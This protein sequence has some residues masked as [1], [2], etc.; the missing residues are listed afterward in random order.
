MCIRGDACPYAH[1][2]FESWL[3]PTRY[4]TQLCTDGAACRRR[5]CFFAHHESEIRAPLPNPPLPSTERLQL[6]LSA[7]PLAPRRR[8]AWGTPALM[9]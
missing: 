1:G 4:R 7:E 9:R 5:V 8:A 3:H 2:I 6:G